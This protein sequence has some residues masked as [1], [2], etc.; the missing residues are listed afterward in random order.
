MSI[1]FLKEKA[2]PGLLLVL[3]LAALGVV[4]SN[5]QSRDLTLPKEAISSKG[6]GLKVGERIPALRAQDQ[7]GEWRDFASLA[8]PRGAVMLFYRSADW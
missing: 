8:G 7:K 3:I 5:S 1:S 4:F 6:P 2:A